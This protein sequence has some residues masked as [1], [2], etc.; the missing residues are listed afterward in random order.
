MIL[1]SGF[2]SFFPDFDKINS[3][4]VAGMVVSFELWVDVGGAV[5]LVSVVVCW[6]PELLVLLLFW[7]PEEITG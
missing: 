2:G 4:S 7:H 3:E 6:F 5:E 1:F